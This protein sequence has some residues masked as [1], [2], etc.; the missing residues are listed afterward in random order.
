[1]NSRPL[2][3]YRVLH[4]Q[5]MPNMPSQ[6]SQS[7]RSSVPSRKVRE[8]REPPR[9]WASKTANKRQKLVPTP[10]R[11]PTPSPMRTFP[12][13]ISHYP[14]LQG[15]ILHL[16]K[17]NTSSLPPHSSTENASWSTPSCRTYTVGIVHGTR[18]YPSWKYTTL[19]P[20]MRTVP[21]RG[22]PVSQ[23]SQGKD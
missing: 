20:N 9:S 1:M 5:F 22:H 18:T 19:H 21:Q 8:N 7:Q 10:H 14:A 2:A 13:M 17:A 16:L 15:S 6:R 11:I 4:D 12:Q 23:R 3:N